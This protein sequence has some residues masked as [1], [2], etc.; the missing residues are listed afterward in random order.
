[1]AFVNQRLFVFNYFKPFN[2]FK[3]IFFCDVNKPKDH[4]N[5]ICV[6]PYPQRMYGSTRLLYNHDDKRGVFVGT[7]DMKTLILAGFTITLRAH[8]S[9]IVFTN[10]KPIFR[11]TLLALNDTKIAAKDAGNQAIKKLIKLLMNAIAGKLGQHLEHTITDF[12]ED[13]Y[14]SFYGRTEQTSTNSSLHYIA[15]LITGE[16]RFYIYSTIYKLHESYLYKKCTLEQMVGIICYCDTDSLTYDKSLADNV[17]FKIGDDLATWDDDNCSFICNWKEKVYKG[18]TGLF[19]LGRK[20]YVPCNVES[21]ALISKTLKGVH[22]SLLNY[23]TFDSLKQICDGQ[24]QELIRKTLRKQNITKENGNV[25][26]FKTMLETNVSFH[27]KI[28]NN[29]KA[30]ECHNPIVFEKNKDCLL[31]EIYDENKN[32][33]HFLEFVVS[34]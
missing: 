34:Q 20:S 24:P 11:E 28:Q 30:I 31:K 21:K 19:I 26:F 29:N 9:S 32:I 4:L 10:L 33:K 17:E 25:N 15:S 3:G 18:Q 8:T 7:A 16:A 12:Y 23:I 22:S 6:A 13:N 14:N 2:E 27:L 5:N 1:M